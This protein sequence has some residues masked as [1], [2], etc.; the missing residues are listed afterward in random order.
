MSSTTIRL[1]LFLLPLAL[2][3]AEPDQNALSTTVVTS[4][5]TVQLDPKVWFKN[6]SVPRSICTDAEMSHV[7]NGM[8]QPLNEPVVAAANSMSSSVVWVA[9]FEHSTRRGLRGHHNSNTVEE[10]DARELGPMA[11]CERI[12]G[13][14]SWLC[15]WLCSGLHRRQLQVIFEEGSTMLE[16][17]R[18]LYALTTSLERSL[19][20]TCW[21]T[22]NAKAAELSSPCATAIIR[23]DCFADV[24]VV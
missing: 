2:V 20:D 21:H 16:R 1:I 11:D 24:R 15:G 3:P 19:R 17:D 5:R 10:I 8:V 18:E 23:A 6:P 7:L 14:G 13:S 12:C 9:G 4:T 22:K